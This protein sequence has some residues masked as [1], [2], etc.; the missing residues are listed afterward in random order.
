ML[1]ARSSAVPY[2]DDPNGISFCP[3]AVSLPPV[4]KRNICGLSE[5]HARRTSVGKRGANHV[6][7]ELYTHSPRANLL[8]S[9]VRSRTKS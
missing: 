2:F 3:G 7:D 9:V 8:S 6:V 5:S 1:A 4:S